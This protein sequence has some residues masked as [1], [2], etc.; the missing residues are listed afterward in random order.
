M[1]RPPRISP[2][3]GGC[4][5]GCVFLT[6]ERSEGARGL[7]GVCLVHGCARILMVLSL[8]IRSESWGVTT[9]AFVTVSKHYLGFDLREF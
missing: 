9:H 4:T 1:T 5:R 6:K 8:L 3:G 7:E 2:V